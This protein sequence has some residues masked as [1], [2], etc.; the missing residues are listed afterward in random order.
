MANPLP[1]SQPSGCPEIE[2]KYFPFN[3]IFTFGKRKQPA[4]T[5]SGEQGG[6]LK[7][8]TCFFAKNVCT[9]S[10]LG[11]VYCCAT[12]T[13]HAN[14]PLPAG[15][16]A[17]SAV[18]VLKMS[19]YIVAFIVCPSGMNSLCN[20][21]PVKTH[22]KHCLHIPLLKVDFLVMGNFYP[23]MPLTVSL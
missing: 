17:F 12:R 13:S 16:V 10:A 2:S 7:H 1:S 15:P 8:V 5:R 6:W 4:G 14:K 19:Q 21:L 18:S 3:V 22:H 20:T 23:P 11:M 9:S